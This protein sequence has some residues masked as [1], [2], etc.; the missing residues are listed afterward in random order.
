MKTNDEI[1]DIKINLIRTQN[2][3]DDETKK[4]AIELRSA[5]IRIME[6]ELKTKKGKNTQKYWQAICPMKNSVQEI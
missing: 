3:H 5:E 2:F 1:I 4:K 6:I